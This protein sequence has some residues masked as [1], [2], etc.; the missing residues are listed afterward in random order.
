VVHL[1]P[2]R[3]EAKARARSRPADPSTWAGCSSVD[4]PG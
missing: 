4:E 3:S 2:A 1:G